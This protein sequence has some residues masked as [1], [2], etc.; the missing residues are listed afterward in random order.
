[1]TG[2]TG[3]D[4][5][6]MDGVMRA[7]FDIPAADERF[8]EVDSEFVGVSESDNDDSEDRESDGGA[9]IEDVGGP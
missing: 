9:A 1:M 8:K 2:R 5:K 4:D 6:S 3:R 7:G